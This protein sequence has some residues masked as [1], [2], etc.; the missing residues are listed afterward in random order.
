MGQRVEQL[1]RRIDQLPLAV[2][3]APRGADQ[4][5]RPYSKYRRALRLGKWG[6]LGCGVAGGIFGLAWSLTRTPVYEARTL[7]EVIEAAKPRPA[8]SYE[9]MVRGDGLRRRTS[10]KVLAAR[11]DWS[12]LIESTASRVGVQWMPAEHLIQ[13][14]C[15][16]ADSELA[17]QYA[18]TLAAEFIDQRL[19]TGW[20]ST[21]HAGEW[22]SGRLGRLQSKLEGEDLELQRAA[23]L[24][25][26]GSSS[27]AAQRLRQT[28][29]EASRAQA[30]R[31]AA[32]AKYELALHAPQESLP[33][34]L[35]D[36]ALRA[37]RRNLADLRRQVADLNASFTPE[38][39]SIRR[40]QAQIA[41]IESDIANASARIIERLKNDLTAA[42]KRESLLSAEV[43]NQ[44]AALTDRAALA[45]R[46]EALRRTADQDRQLYTSLTER[47]KADQIST[48][49]EAV[50]FRIA[51]AAPVPKVRAARD[52]ATAPLLGLLSGLSVGILLATLRAARDRSVGMPGDMQRCLGA[53]ELGVIPKRSLDPHRDTTPLERA[54]FQRNS[55]M[56]ESFRVTLTSLLLA[57]R[58]R[59]LPRSI[60][61]TSAGPGEGKTTVACNLAIGYAEMNWQVLLIDGDLRC[62]RLEEVFSVESEDGLAA[63]LLG[64][65]LPS[66]LRSLVRETGV[67]NLSILPRGKPR[68]SIVEAL[69]P[70]LFTTLLEEARRQ[71]DVVLID[72]PPMLYLPD[73][74]AVAQA[75]D[76]VVFVARAQK[77]E[78]DAVVSSREILAQDG[79]RVLGSVLNDWNP[80]A[81]GF[82]AG[83]REYRRYYKTR[84]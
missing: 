69:Q 43:A 40:L 24:N 18:N 79:I 60:A 68:G 11:S 77:T 48:A 33:E 10:A 58:P 78:R 71:Y 55:M 27:T 30:D 17:A 23:E 39:P 6:I 42:R 50:R 82:E 45:A 73:A 61:V 4:Q 47:V 65:K 57:D 63:I 75:T 81:S 67:P 41:S 28:Q 52:F 34:V 7:I 80:R 16:S 35:D 15:R 26:D 13:I 20:D 38:Y 14:T 29:A 31:V 66:E 70:A 54:S 72:T 8:I 37:G 12:S 56:A 21:Q 1:A 19:E 59:G 25:A 46:T 64:T 53:P 3:P 49:L 62:P 51:D 9:A 36:D 2:P 76:G 84:S 74:R 32:Q 83:F 22:L 5:Q 44:S